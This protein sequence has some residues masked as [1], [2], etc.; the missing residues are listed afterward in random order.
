MTK[1]YILAL[2]IAQ[3]A[4]VV[5]LDRA[6]GS[7]VW[8]DTVTT[9]QSGWRSLESALHRHHADWSGT[10][11][12]MEATG[13]LHL[14]WAERLVAA[15]ADV[16]VLNPLLTARLESFSNALRQ[17]KTDRVD[18]KRLAETARLHANELGRF[19][20]HRDC[21]QQARRQLDRVRATLRH[22]LT[23]VKKALKSHLE[24]V[25]PALMAARIEPDTACAA[26]I[27]RAATTAPAW[28]ALPPASRRD[29]AASKCDAL[30]QACRQTLS[31]PTLATACAPAVLTLLTAMESLVANL[32]D[33]DQQIATHRPEDRV[34]LIMSIPGFGELTA[35]VLATYL[36][37]DFEGWGNKKQIAARLQALFG[38]DPRL[39]QSG[40]WV[41][42]IKMSKR[43]IGSARTALF[44]SAFCSL[45]NDPENAA[46]YH[47][48]RDR[49]KSHKTAIVDVMRKQLRRLSAVLVSNQPFVTRKSEKACVAA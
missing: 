35:T 42:K 39:R 7:L 40:K 19:R 4:A 26:R 33:C 10:L 8:R 13:I 11:V 23:N 45:R 44:Q 49:G 37:A 1:S 24:L 18:A 25:F 32:E 5:Q 3:H 9:D 14:S 27:L 15:G 41:G 43:G 17:H 20:Y 28:L 2:D 48:L 6:D 34:R 21:D 36:P 12:I 46:Y 22:N 16:Y 29:L 30:D 47:S 31:D 38:M